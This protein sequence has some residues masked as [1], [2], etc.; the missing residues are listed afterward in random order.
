MVAPWV[1]KF[2]RYRITLTPPV[3]NHAACVLFLVSGK[4]KAETLREVLQGDDLY[5][6][7]P[8][9]VIRPT[10]GRLLWLVDRAAAHLLRRDRKG[11]SRRQGQEGPA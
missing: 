11:E 7:F 4:E 6:R 5:D 10:N 3:L 8:A 9:K 1:E 2:H